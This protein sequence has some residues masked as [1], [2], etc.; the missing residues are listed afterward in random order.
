MVTIEKLGII[1]GPTDKQ[2]ENNGVFNP[3]INQEE[4]TIDILYRPEE[5]ANN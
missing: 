5:Q 1:L 2:F 3:G 4:N